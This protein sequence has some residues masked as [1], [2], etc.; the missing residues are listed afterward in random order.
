MGQ[1]AGLNAA[2]GAARTRL[3]HIPH[4]LQM[5]PEVAWAGITEEQA[6]ATRHDVITGV[7][8]LAYNARAIALGA[9]EG[10]VKVVAERELGEVLGVHVA[11]PGAAEI[12]NIAAALMQAEVSLHDLA[13]MTFWHPSMGEGLVEA[14]RRALSRT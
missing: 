1:V 10:I 11:G 9:R 3:A 13:A 12:A 4:V 7:F 5:F 2:G 6:V 14:A 8:D